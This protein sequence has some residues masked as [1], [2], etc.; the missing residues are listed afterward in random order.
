MYFQNI[1]VVFYTYLLISEPY[2]NNISVSKS[3][4]RPC[5]GD[6]GNDYCRSGAVDF[7]WANS[8]E[9]ILNHMWSI[10]MTMISSSTSRKLLAT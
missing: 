10:A 1:Y 5:G 9:N 6:L 2:P 7:G 8:E 4:L 3:D